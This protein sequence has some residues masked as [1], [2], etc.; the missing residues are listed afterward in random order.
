MT[1]CL[2][3]HIKNFY[4][5]SQH[6]KFMSSLVTVQSQLHEFKLDTEHFTQELH[7]AFVL[8][9]NEISSSNPWSRAGKVCSVSYHGDLAKIKIR[10]PPW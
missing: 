1:N 4:V 6:L 9:H 10:E 7:V 5:S 8:S 2:H 3:F